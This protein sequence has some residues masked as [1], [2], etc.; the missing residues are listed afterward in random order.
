MVKGN[1][2]ALLGTMKDVSK[3]DQLYLTESC[4]L[5]HEQLQAPGPNDWLSS[6]S[7]EGQT[8]NDFKLRCEKCKQ[9]IGL[10]P[11]LKIFPLQC[12]NEEPR[13]PESILNDLM[14]YAMAFFQCEV[15]IEAYSRA[16]IDSR[17]NSHTN[18]LQFNCRGLLSEL[19]SRKDQEYEVKM[20]TTKKGKD[21]K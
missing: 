17:S 15:V 4:L 7:E 14:S 2:K 3:V 5:L 13:V 16:K 20:Q 1:L 9:K 10:K 6:H 11:L 18:I 19:H 12:A 21:Q 8:F